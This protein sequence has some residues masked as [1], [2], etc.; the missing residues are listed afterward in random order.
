MK[1][2]FVLSVLLYLF[3]KIG[4][5]QISFL[6][7]KSIWVGSRPGV[8]AISDLNDDGLN[9]VL[10]ATTYY[11]DPLNDFCLFIF[12]QDT[13]GSLKVPIKLR[14]ASSYHPRVCISVADLNN[15]QK[16]DIVLGRADSIFIFYQNLSGTFNPLVRHYSGIDVDAMETGDLNNDGLAD[17]AVAHW[18]DTFIRIFYQD[19]VLG[20]TSITYPQVQSGWDELEVGDITND[21]LN[22]LVFLTQQTPGAV[23]IY[24]QKPSGILDTAISFRPTSNALSAS[25]RGFDIGDVSN[26]GI[27]D[28]AFSNGTNWPDSYIYLYIQD[29]AAGVLKFPDSLQSYDQPQPVEIADLNC[30]GRN[31]IIT[32][33]GGFHCFSVFEQDSLNRYK[34]PLLFYLPYASSYEPQGLCVGDINNDGKKDVVIADYNNGL[35]LLINNTHPLIMSNIDTLLSTDTVFIKMDTKSRYFHKE[36]VIE[37]TSP[38]LINQ[39]DVFLKNDYYRID[40]IQTDTFFVRE[41]TNCSLITIDTIQKSLSKYNSTYIYSDTSHIST[42]IDTIISISLSDLGI[43]TNIKIFPV[44]ASEKVTISLVSPCLK[45]YGNYEVSLMLY[46]AKGN[47]INAQKAMTNDFPIEMN[48]ANYANGMYFL[49]CSSENSF[50]VKKIVKIN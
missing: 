4:C 29:T 36:Q 23:Y 38:C 3:P 11:F 5:S 15:D 48:L 13:T 35:L 32:A 9:D 1:G 12:Y 26:D 30:D 18:N 27:N 14:Y 45:Y 47:E 7:Y 41:G 19:T 34:P 16:K 43:S 28:L 20:L 22:D 24:K 40:T 21:G 2:L 6:P 10:L 39:T 42:T 31:E 8:V 46:D 50:V 37:G 17:I 33:N 44:P 49:K 25:Y